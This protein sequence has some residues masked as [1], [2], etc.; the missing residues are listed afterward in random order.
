MNSIAIVMNRIR[1]QQSPQALFWHDRWLSYPELVRRIDEWKHR[2]AGWGVGEGTVCAVQGDY[3]PASCAAIFA[4]VELRAIVVPF[5]RTVEK[6]APA[7]CRIA[8]VQC[9][10]RLDEG[11]EADFR[12]LDP[13]QPPALLAE[14]LLLG[15]PGLVVF[16][17]GS[18][19]V[20]KAI[21]H[22]CERV[23]HKFTEPRQGWRTLLFLL[24]DH[25]GGFNTLLATFA[26]GGAGI[27]LPDRDPSTVCRL[28]AQTRAEL[29]PVT[30]TFLNFLLTTGVYREYDLSSIRLI[31]YGT[32]VMLPAT[33]KKIQ[34]AFPNARFKQTYG[35]SELG[36]LQS[37]SEQDDSVWLR[38]GG[39]GFETKVVDGVLWVRSQANMVGYLN[40][41]TPIDSDGWMCTDDQVEI[42]G[43]Y[44]RFLGRRTELINVG[45]QK[46]YPS[47]VENVLL[48]A[49]NICEASVSGM[50]HPV[51]G[52]AVQARVSLCRPEDEEVLRER[53]RQFCLDRLARYKVPMR[54]NIVA[55][56]AQHSQRYK[57]IHQ[58]QT[59]KGEES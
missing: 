39:R 17:S 6:E 32:E 18:T 28:V 3:S 43:E 19:G 49:E 52:Q 37:S 50:P 24:M 57:K 4:L 35:M 51:L 2:L 22:D 13:G 33:L 55:P 1:R 48:E 34:A 42:D 7:F 44:L 29:M 53:L 31:T 36:V 38:V 47:E 45:G 25:F 59:R 56:T 27:C 21:L 40:A 14:F 26:Y 8:G 54:F 11:D 5:T 30:P 10:L 16:S 46:V 23:F 20:P 9:M 41:T 15:H 12:R 58:K